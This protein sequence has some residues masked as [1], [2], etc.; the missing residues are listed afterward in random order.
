ML[1]FNSFTAAF[2]EL[3]MQNRSTAAS[4]AFIIGLVSVIF[5]FIG[6]S[7]PMGAFGVIVALLSRGNGEMEGKA[8]A[9]L[10][11]SMAGMAYGI[12]STIYS[13]YLLTTPEFSKMIETIQS[14]IG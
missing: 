12:Y 5:I 9:G 8:K 6:M 10:A 1:Q 11:L 3:F 7:L 2:K 13:V 4:T 14:L